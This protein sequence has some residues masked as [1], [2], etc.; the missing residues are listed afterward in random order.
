MNK[1]EV[2]R[3]RRRSRK[4]GRRDFLKL[5]AAGLGGA[6][7]CSLGGLTACSPEDDG[8]YDAVVVGGG[9]SGLTAAYWLQDYDVLV[10]EKE[11]AAGGRVLTREW[12]GFQYAMGAAYM[13]KPDLEMSLF[14]S[15]LGIEAIPVPPPA[16][17]LA[18]QGIVYPEDYFDSALG[19]I[20]AFRDYVRVSE[21]LYEYADD[22]IEEATYE[23]DLETLAEYE[24][25]DQIS[26]KQWLDDEGVHPLV[27]RYIDV[28]NRG[29]FGVSNSDMSLLFDV[30]EMSFNLYEEGLDE[31]DYDPRPVPDFQTFRP[32][33]G[34]DSGV[35]TFANGMIEMVWALEEALEGRVQSG[36]EV[37]SVVVNG[38]DTVSVTYTR[39]GQVQTVRA[40]AVV[41]AAPA[42]VTASIVRGG[43][44]SNVMEAL[45]AVSYTTYVTM[46]VFLRERLFR[47]AWNVACLDAVFTTL[48][49][50]IR[51]QVE[52]DYQGGSILGVAMPP[53]SAD[54]RSLIALSDDALLERALH[55]IERYFPGVR[56]MVVGK[57]VHR[58]Q[59]AFPVFRPGYGEIL[60]ELHADETTMGPLFLAG[61][62]MV[63][64]TLGGA[65]VSGWRAYELVTEYANSLRWLREG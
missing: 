13:G 18:Y 56:D 48:N 21:E 35:W 19:S 50:A 32:D 31:F 53:D 51:T 12:E 15:E 25:L 40:Y 52:Y 62:Y 1:Q 33:A 10:L 34:E 29:L 41:L 61:D 27:Q 45:R 23:A 47:N 49:D 24:E 65:A 2:T 8:V 20:E 6:A 3:R 28:E 36:A 59:Y 57:D 5:S 16:D 43:F 64:P 46:A 42:P 63:Y 44:S 38:D 7:L 39:N 9:V 60:W 37:S 58:F 22:G 26:V 14:F 55:D 30:P 54:D 4:L 17:A 11:A